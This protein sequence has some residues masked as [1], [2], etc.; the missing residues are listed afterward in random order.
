MTNE[1][2]SQDQSLNVHSPYYLHPGENLAIALVSPVLDL[3]NYNAWSHSMLTTL[4][5][6]NKIKFIDGS[7]QMCIKSSTSCSLEEMQQYSGFL[8]CPLSF[9]LNKSEY[10]MDG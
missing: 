2:S 3:I 5:A 1:I 8:A 9:T 4:S 10:L 6:K 7:I